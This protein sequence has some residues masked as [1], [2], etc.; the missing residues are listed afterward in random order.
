MHIE[1]PRTILDKKALVNRG[2]SVVDEKYSG[3]GSSG[4]RIH[5]RVHVR[6]GDRGVHEAYIEL[7]HGETPVAGI[8]IEPKAGET[9]LMHPRGGWTM[10]KD[11]R[12]PTEIRSGEEPVFIEKPTTYNLKKLSCKMFPEV[13]GVGIIVEAQRSGEAHINKWRYVL[14]RE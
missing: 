2:M 13:G 3:P 12:P 4:K 11:D 5:A 10:K 8:H 9:L 7:N 6:E 1:R 14:R